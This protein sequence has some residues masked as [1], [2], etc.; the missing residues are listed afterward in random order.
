MSDED[1]SF[2][3]I[4]LVNGVYFLKIGDTLQQLTRPQFRVLMGKVIDVMQGE[5]PAHRNVGHRP[6]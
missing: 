3:S 4:R 1:L 2:V 6:S 5:M